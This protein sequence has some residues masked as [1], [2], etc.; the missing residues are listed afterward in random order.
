MNTFK[1]NTF[2]KA[3]ATALVLALATAT[4]AD[5]ATTAPRAATTQSVTGKSVRGK[6]VMGRVGGA[7]VGAHE[8]EGGISLA[9]RHHVHVARRFAKHGTLAHRVLGTK[10]ALTPALRHVAANRHPGTETSVVR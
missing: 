2:F 4:V 10:V 8:S 1:T 3:A 5:A 7:K 9:N 6:S